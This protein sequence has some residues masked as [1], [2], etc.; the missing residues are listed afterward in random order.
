ME[1]KSLV[2][3]K[4]YKTEL[5]GKIL[6]P[7]ACWII[8][9]ATVVTCIIAS[10]VLETPTFYIIAGAVAIIQIC[11]VVSEA[12]T[13]LIVETCGVRYKTQFFPWQN[14]AVT[15]VLGLAHKNGLPSI[16]VSEGKL[17]SKTVRK[18]TIF[19]MMFTKNN[20][21]LLCSTC[22]Q[23]IEILDSCYR[24]LENI[25]IKQDPDGLIAK[26]N[27]KVDAMA[28]ENNSSST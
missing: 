26:H 10:I 20:L 15:V 28:M 22:S 23:K 14:V 16:V 7:V 8:T 12:T 3:G 6:S 2:I 18:Q 17:N 25:K 9:I 11:A 4:L 19:R 5:Y 13:P 27:A 1:K 24:P 21:L